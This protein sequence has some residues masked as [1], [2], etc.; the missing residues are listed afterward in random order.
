M[1]DFD[2]LALLINPIWISRDFG[3]KWPQA[4]VIAAP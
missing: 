1:F 3:F 2:V 4:F